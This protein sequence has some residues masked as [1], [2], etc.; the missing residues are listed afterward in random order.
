MVALDYLLMTLAILIPIT[1][2]LLLIIYVTIRTFASYTD[3]GKSKKAKKIK[4]KKFQAITDDIPAFSVDVNKK[5]K[6]E[7]SFGGG[8]I[9]EVYEHSSQD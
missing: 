2:S 5:P 3:I 4:E 7:T 8:R 6:I 9:G 1:I